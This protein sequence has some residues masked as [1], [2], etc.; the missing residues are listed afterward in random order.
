MEAA[1][2]LLL[3]LGQVERDAVG[4]GQPADEHQHER[5]RLHEPEPETGLQLR[6]DDAHHAQRSGGQDD[7]DQRHRDGD[8]VADELRGRP[9][10]RQQRILAVGGPAGQDDPV[11]TDR[12]HRDDEEQP[13]V[14]IGDVEQRI[15]TERDH[16]KDDQRR[17]HRHDRRQGEEPLVSLRRGDVL[18][19]HQLDRVHNRLQQ[20]PGPDPHRPEPRLHPPLDLPLEQGHDGDQHEH[21]VEHHRDLEQRDDDD[22]DHR[23]LST[24]PSTMSMVPISA[25]TSATRCPMINDLSPCRLQNDGG[26]TRNR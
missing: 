24:S 14:D 17:H 15:P 5:D 19:Q 4:L 22:V 3:R 12:G 26:R 25:T 9:Q 8:L 2:Q 13:D 10:T 16:R 20:A 11:D 1:R 23:Y 6:L 21:P 7:A 18:L